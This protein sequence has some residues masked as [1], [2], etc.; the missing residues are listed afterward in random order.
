MSYFSWGPLL[1]VAFPIRR[2]PN[3]VFNGRVHLLSLPQ[4]VGITIVVVIVISFIDYISI[5]LFS[6]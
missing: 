1:E 3:D 2:D 6:L 4:E 5:I